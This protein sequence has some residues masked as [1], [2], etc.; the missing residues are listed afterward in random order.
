LHW[1]P[2]VTHVL[3][4]AQDVLFPQFTGFVP[5]PWGTVITQG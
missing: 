5:Q 4:A 1:H 3:L 2:F